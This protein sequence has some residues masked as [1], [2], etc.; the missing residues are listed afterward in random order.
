MLALSGRSLIPDLAI[1]PLK[2]RLFSP[3]GEPLL[4]TVFVH[5]TKKRGHQLSAEYMAAMPKPPL[6]F[7]DSDVLAGEASRFLK[8][9]VCHCQPHCIS[10]CHL[11]QLPI[12]ANSTRLPTPA[13]CPHPQYGRTS[14]ISS[15]PLTN[16][17]G[18]TVNMRS[19]SLLRARTV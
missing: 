2:V 11:L 12:D 8:I 10:V 16:H 17:P 15:P 9:K 13:C 5:M 6:H 14:C 7:Q 18:N 1:A 4:S 19:T 3:D